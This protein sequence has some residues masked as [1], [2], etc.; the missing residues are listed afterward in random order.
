MINSPV[1]Q[2]VHGR[3][4]D[5]Q[6]TFPSSKKPVSTQVDP[7]QKPKMDEDSTRKDRKSELFVSKSPNKKSV[8]IQQILKAIGVVTE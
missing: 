6:R 4:K 7:K 3:N 1:K 2:R 8:Q 5:D